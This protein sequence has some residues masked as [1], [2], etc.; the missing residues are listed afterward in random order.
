MIPMQVTEGLLLLLKLGVS[1]FDAIT[2]GE[3]KAQTIRRARSVLD[4]AAKVDSDV[5]A[6]AR[7][8]HPEAKRRAADE[9]KE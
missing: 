8:T 9:P 1:I 2:R 4:D 6:E 7:G 3:G 5:D